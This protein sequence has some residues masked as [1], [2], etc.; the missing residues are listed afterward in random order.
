MPGPNDWPNPLAE[1]SRTFQSALKKR[2]LNEAIQISWAAIRR[3]KTCGREIMFLATTLAIYNDN[4]GL[5]L[6]RQRARERT[7]ADPRYQPPYRSQFGEDG[8]VDLLDLIQKGEAGAR[9][10]HRVLDVLLAQPGLTREE[11]S[12][13]LHVFES[14]AEKNAY[15]KTRSKIEQV[16]EW[17]TPQDIQEIL[18]NACRVKKGKGTPNRYF[19][20]QPPEIIL[21]PDAAFFESTLQ[22]AAPK[23]NVAK[24]STPSSS[25]VNQSAT[26]CMVLLAILAISLLLFSLL[27]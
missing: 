12:E 4:E 18:S 20:L 24:V 21:R 17:Y 16:S 22:P 3:S 5:R 6:L 19:A 23:A 13:R 1:R 26:G 10:T 7:A 25:P 2:R 8:N 14:T 15:N 11:I 9:R 27:G